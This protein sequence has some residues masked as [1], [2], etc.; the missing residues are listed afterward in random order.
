MVMN[1]SKWTCISKEDFDLIERSFDH[2]FEYFTKQLKNR[3]NKKVK[4][5]E[6]GIPITKQGTKTE[7]ALQ[8]RLQL[9]AELHRDMQNVPLC[10]DLKTPKKVPKKALKKPK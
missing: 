3:E 2:I 10:E 9:Y 6:M 1:D 5:A 8:D 4:L 7:Q